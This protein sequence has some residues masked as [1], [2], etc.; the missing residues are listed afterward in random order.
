MEGEEE[1]AVGPRL[2]RLADHQRP[3][4]ALEDR[5]RVHR[6][7]VVVEPGPFGPFV[8]LPDVGEGAVPLDEAAGVG[9]LALVGAVH[10]VG[11]EDP[12]RVHRHRRRQLVA[13]VDDDGVA[14]FG[15]DQRPRHRRLAQRAFEPGAV[16]P[17]AVGAELRLALSPSGPSSGRG[18]WG[19]CPTAPA[20]PRSST[21]ASGRRSAATPAAAP[22][23][24]RR[25]TPPPSPS[26]APSPAR[27]S[28]STS[29]LPFVGRDL[30]A[31]DRA[32]QG[33][34]GEGEEPPPVDRVGR[35][36]RPTS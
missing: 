27:A 8:G 10:L 23:G 6:P 17:V 36:A 26:A 24:P 16:E 18:G 32:E 9:P 35:H 3:E 13:E 20:R 15:F 22:P 25:A 33:A 30:L 2:A 14:D 4:Q 7:V 31:G 5:Q 34:A 11:V 1:L 21:R 12:V 28:P 29:I 19:R